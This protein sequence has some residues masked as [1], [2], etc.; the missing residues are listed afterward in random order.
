MR[1]KELQC[2]HLSYSLAFVKTIYILFQLASNSY[3][4]IETI[5]LTT[6][7]AVKPTTHIVSLKYNNT[8]IV[9]IGI[10]NNNNTTLIITIKMIAKCIHCNE[11]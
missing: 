8:L 7:I 4:I 2:I 9:S 5:G 3:K 11:Y 1:L 10:K 6:L